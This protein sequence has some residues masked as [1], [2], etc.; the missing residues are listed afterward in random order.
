MRRRPP[1]VEVWH[2]SWLDLS[3]TIPLSWWQAWSPAAIAV[4]G[5][6]WHREGADAPPGQ[7]TTWVEAADDDPAAI[8][9]AIRE[10]QVAISATRDGPLLLR[11]DGGLVA[12][13]ADGLTLAGPEGGYLL[14]NGDLAVL[15]GKPGYHRLLDA[16]G[17]TLALTS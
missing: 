12:V 15:P 11:V 17:A 5:S 7:P 16:R 1:L 10:G 14:V 6:D 2:W 8:L 4:G 13:D 9:A 3:W